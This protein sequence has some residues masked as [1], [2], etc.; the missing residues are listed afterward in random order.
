MLEIK[1]LEIY[2]NFNNFDDNKKNSNEI[3][4]LTDIIIKSKKAHLFLLQPVLSEFIITKEKEIKLII[5][6]IFKQISN[7]MGVDDFNYE[8]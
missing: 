2:P 8:I 5:R 6:D 7:Q 3:I 4:K 1:N